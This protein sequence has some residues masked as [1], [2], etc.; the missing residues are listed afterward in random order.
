VGDGGFVEET[1]ANSG[2]PAGWVHDCGE[3]AVAA[4][5]AGS[6]RQRAPGAVQWDSIPQEPHPWRFP[7]LPFPPLPLP[8]CPFHFLTSPF[9]S[10]SKKKK[11]VVFFFFFF[12]QS[13]HASFWW[14]WWA[15]GTWTTRSTTVGRLLSGAL[16]GPPLP[17]VL[18]AHR[19]GR[20]A[21]GRK[22]VDPSN[23]ISR[24]WPRAA[25]VAGTGRY[26]PNHNCTT[27]APRSPAVCAVQNV[28]A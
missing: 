23:L 25:A 7:P 19:G 14:P 28:C 13:T 21:C 3:L 20:P 17:R 11:K 10:L 24:V 4:D 15:S 27:L 18:C 26:P 5:Q 16:R 12:A 8:S 2:D 6:G 22:T 1:F 9:L